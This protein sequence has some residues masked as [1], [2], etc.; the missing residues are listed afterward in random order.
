MPSSCDSS[1]L[2]LV[3]FC[4]LNSA[5]LFF[6]INLSGNIMTMDVGIVESMELGLIGLVN[7]KQ[8]KSP[9]YVKYKKGPLFL[10]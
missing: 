8:I 3:N 9:N 5:L 2:N 6:H 1:S 4:C 10:F 7:F